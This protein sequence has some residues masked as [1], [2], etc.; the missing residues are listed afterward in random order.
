[1]R[2]INTLPRLGAVLAIWTLVWL[3]LIYVSELI[4]PLPQHTLLSCRLNDQMAQ[5]VCARH[6][7]KRINHDAS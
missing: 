4:A 7:I 3:A 2:I 5:P 1:M 6:S